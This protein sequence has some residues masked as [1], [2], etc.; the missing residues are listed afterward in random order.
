MSRG[1]L[2]DTVGGGAGPKRTR[3]AKIH[4]LT[5]AII[6]VDSM[7]FIPRLLL[8]FRAGVRPVV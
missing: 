1:A 2:E 7:D 3:A 5:S 8:V 6:F 4:M